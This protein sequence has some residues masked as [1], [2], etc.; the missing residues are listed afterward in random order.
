M[1]HLAVG[2]LKKLS[3]YTGNNPVKPKAKSTATSSIQREAEN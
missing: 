1:V 2:H 3:V